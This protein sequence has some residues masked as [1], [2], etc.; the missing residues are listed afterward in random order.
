MR[1]SAVL[2]VSLAVVSAGLAG[3]AAVAAAT[4]V[5]AGGAPTPAAQFR[6]HGSRPQSVLGTPV[7]SAPAAGTESN[8]LAAAPDR[9]LVRVAAAG[10]S[11]AVAAAVRRLGGRVL[12]TAGGSSS[13]LV[14]PGKVTALRQAAGVVQVEPAERPYPLTAGPSEGVS[15]SGADVW[16]SA[17]QT[18]A[19]T[20]IAIVDVGFGTSAAEYSD[21]VTAGYLGDN[22]QLINETCTD[23]AEPPSPTPYVEAHGLAV[24]ELAHQ[25]APGAQ[26]YLYCVGDNTGLVKAEA[27][28][29]AAGIRIASSSLGWFGDSRGDGT[30]PANSAA[31]VV[32]KARKAGVLWIQSAGNEAADHWGRIM[33]D[34]DHDHYLDINGPYNESKNVYE[35]DFVYV[36]GGG[37]APTSAAVH[38]QWDQW[39]TTTTP[40]S[41][42]LY[43]VQCRDSF[44]SGVGIDGCRGVAINPDSNGHPRPITATHASG[45][46]PVVEADTSRFANTSQYDQVWEVVVYSSGTLPK[47]RYDFNYEGDLD[48]VS[49]NA[50]ASVN[51]SD[52]CNL[53]ADAYSHSIT[54][55]ADSPYVLA[56]GAAA[57]TIS[58]TGGGPGSREYFSSEGPTIDGRVKPDITGWDAVSSYVPEYADQG[59]YGTSAAAPQVAGAAALVAAAEPGW[60]AAQIQNFLEQRANSSKPA[61]PPS[62]ATGHG[63][64]TLGAPDTVALPPAAKYTPITPKRI[65]DTR[66]AGTKKPLGAGKTVTVPVSADIP[67]DAT[68]VAI[69]LTGVSATGT[70]YLAAY[71]GGRAWPGTSN[72]NLPE[73]DVTAAVF[74]VVSIDA[75]HR[76]ITVRNSSA[77]AHVLIDELGYFGTGDE[78]GAYTAL[79]APRRVLDTRTTTG[80]HHGKVTVTSSAPVDP[81]LPADAT[82]AVVNITAVGAAGGGH[83]SA[84]AG[85]VRATSTLNYGKYV[86]ANLAV[87][88]L[89]PAGRFC[90][91]GSGGAVDVLVDVLGYMSPTG[92]SYYALPAGTRIVD[93]RTGNGGNAGGRSP[94]PIGE[95]ATA[96]FYGA[97]VGVV[98]GAASALL[99]GLVEASSTSSGYLSAVPYAAR[100]TA[101][102]SLN[103]TYGR[104]VSNA[105]VIGLG[106]GH[107][108]SVYN[109]RGNA[110]VVVDLFGYF[111]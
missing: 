84:A 6:A 110:H 83:L 102:S 70:T 27:A 86:R 90:I 96:T 26:L 48:G 55:P 16:A 49:D 32:A 74:A 19:G 45:T 44:S 5:T 65:L 82:A 7:R 87:V 85:C 100:P 42:R 60:D 23:E 25:E 37:T 54:A 76:S 108:F 43:G 18:G 1:R 78:T 71:T 69:N 80:G 21:A 75:T 104:V 68:A 12:A 79:A 88:G 101:S 31:A 52:V 66:T 17:G 81:A 58:V 33:G 28:I 64:L 46:K 47:V 77:T 41:L 94:R 111:G 9:G 11:R 106:S 98:P 105:A 67:S 53:A 20:R 107:R 30:G 59:F 91:T 109:S 50:C 35:D 57:A 56:V 62:N 89:D 15:R 14:A 39:P 3:L 36:P 92:A 38:L 95:A 97:D 24:A 10:D 8:P 61:N 40:L 103:Y 93:T 2:A 63:L 72:L 13:V 34:S 22:P 51:A 73:A 29:E 4:P 99:T